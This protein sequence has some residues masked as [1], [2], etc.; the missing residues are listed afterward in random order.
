MKGFIVYA[1]Y[2]IIEEKTFIQL[3]GRL[4]NGQSFVTVNAFEP[5]FFI[6][7]SD[8]QKKERLFKE[9]K[10]EKASLRN[11]KGKKVVKVSASNHQELKKLVDAIHAEEIDTYEADIKPH[12][13]FLIDH[14]LYGSISI[15][16]EYENSEKID[17]IFREPEI[18]TAA[19]QPKLK[20]LSLDTESSHNGG[21][22]YCIGMYGENY[23]K[24]FMIT[25]KKMR[26]VVPCKDEA[27]C[28]QKFR[29]EML[30]YDPDIITG[31]N[32][33][34]F[35]LVYLKELCK[36]RKIPFDIGRNNESVRLRI[37]SGFFKSSSADIPGRQVLDGM[38]LIKDPFI[39][40]AP[41]IKKAE[42]ESF[43]LESVSQ[44]ILGSGK[45]I[46][47]KDRHLEI[48]KLFKTNQQ[49]LVDYNIQ[50][51]KLAYEILR[52]TAM[53]ELAIERSELTGLPLDRLGASV[54]A[55]DSLYIREARKR[56]LVSP[57]TRYTKKEE[58]IIGGYVKSS[59]SGIYNN[60]LVL[61]FKSLYP[62]IL[63]TFNIDPSS[64]L[65]KKEQGA[66][67]SPNKVYFRN[68]EGILPFMIEKLHHAREKAKKENRELSSYAI[69][70]I[71]NSFWGVLANPNCRYFNF[72]MAN[73]ITAFARWAIQLTAQKIEEKG[74]K[75]IYSDTDSCFVET[76]LGK[77]KANA[78]GI[79][80]QDYINS[81]YKKY[82]KENYHRESYLE[83]QFA[84]Q[85]L[86]LMIP[87]V[88]VKEGV[89]T[90]AAKKR[91]AGL[92][93]KGK[94]E[95]LDIV[96]LE[97]IRGDWTIAAHE[98]QRELLL[99]A[100][101]KEP[102]EPF[103]R[104]YIKKIREGKL[105]EKLIYKKSIR[106]ELEEYTKTTP[107]HVKAARQLDRLESN[108]IQYYITEEGPEPIQKL[109]HKIDY[110]H[111]IEKQ[112]KPIAN[113]ILFLLG[114]EFED[115]ATNHKQST[116]F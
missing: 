70:T 58:G 116:L 65:E 54:A 80:I 53:L 32:I 92:I 42:F 68:Q 72:E 47:G 112:I 34:D 44:A 9:Y 52:K 25:D 8:F 69:K 77:E 88:R 1:T 64:L 89:E 37:E 55:F 102:I 16:G 39:K 86:S 83:L 20:V 101:H 97:A 115:L 43:A 61:D 57:T 100:F 5:Y 76:N 71:M 30:A 81:F 13:R 21:G 26:N 82:I 98:F 56:S 29:D 38:N 108:I 93:E 11:F 10:I 90:K 27:E 51:C 110:E 96:G 12:T 31:W 18:K 95:E 62:S 24:T 45:L 91:Y 40:E 3:F 28:L 84:K 85:Y 50:D 49:K 66:I 105:N 114:K 6:S 107:P 79:E 94:E 75:V 35:D 111:Y 103:I 15:E 63:R 73:A 17:R 33:I 99:K 41:S 48:D 109:R 106:K 14:D 36:K 4:E 22:L 23:E 46:K 67:E 59:K 74:Y 113:Q 19:F 7:E 78:L 2:D 60:V 87:S 104:S